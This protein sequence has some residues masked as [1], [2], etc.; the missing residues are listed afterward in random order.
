MARTQRM[1]ESIVE[2]V[3][4]RGF[5]AVW[6]SFTSRPVCAG[7]GSG[8]RVLVVA[9]H[10]DD[11]TLG[12]GG[13]IVLHR[14]AGHAVTVVIMTDGRGSTVTTP[15]ARRLESMAAAEVLGGTWRRFEL[16]EGAWA[17]DRGTDH[18]VAILSDVRPD[19]VYGPSCVDYH[20][21][22]VKVAV[23]LGRALTAV[24]PESRVRAFEIGVPLTPILANCPVDVDAV[25]AIKLQALAAYQSQRATIDAIRRLHRYTRRL[26]G[27]RGEAEVFWETSARTYGRIMSAAPPPDARQFYGVR[28]RPFGDPLCYLVGLRARS[29]MRRLA[30]QDGP[31]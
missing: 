30:L 20:P 26:C 28:P 15:A 31:A 18:L 6:R 3:W 17:L 25:R 11:E 9:P 19:L 21:E 14:R 22:H 10:P 24:S 23:A 29:R 2:T 7:V 5:F 12:C 27:T 1:I 4:A 16:P 8:P 13:S